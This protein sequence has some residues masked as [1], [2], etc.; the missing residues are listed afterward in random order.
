METVAK[1]VGLTKER[2]NTLTEV[3]PLCSYLFVRPKGYS[4]KVYNKISSELTLKIIEE[5]CSQIKKVKSFKA[6]TLS[7]VIKKWIDEEEYSFGS[8]MQPARLALVGELK[9]IDLFLMMEFLGK[10]ESVA[11]LVVLSK[12]IKS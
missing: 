8:V 6:G 1:A 11:R 3:W 9:G 2:A 5:L 4:E 12:N 10:E 7:E